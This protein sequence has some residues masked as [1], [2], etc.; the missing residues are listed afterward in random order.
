MTYIQCHFCK[1]MVDADIFL[2]QM[3]ATHLAPDFF[4][5][6]VLERFKIK[7]WLSLSS[8]TQHIPTRAYRDQDQRVQMIESCLFFIVSILSTRINLGK[9]I[10]GVFLS[11]VTSKE[12]NRYKT[13]V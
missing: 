9:N 6:M 12:V 11:K 7:D 4:L 13:I 8:D 3:C 1:S 2:L 10:F 5:E